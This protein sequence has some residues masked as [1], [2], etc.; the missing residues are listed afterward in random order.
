M[1]FGSNVNL[2]KEIVSYSN[3]KNNV[4]SNNLSNI[5]NPTYKRMYMNDLKFEDT[6]SQSLKCTKEGHLSGINENNNFMEIHTETS[7]GRNDEN[8]VNLDKEIID[9]TSNKYLFEIS[10]S[11]LQKE[12]SKL[13][14][15]II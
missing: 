12:Y 7:K 10:S 5:N 2:T 3:A 14:E 6:L 1:N 8:N 15:A 4:I 9:L 11:V 13:R